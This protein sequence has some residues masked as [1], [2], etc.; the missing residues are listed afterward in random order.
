MHKLTKILESSK[1]LREYED[2]ELYSY[3]GIT[4]GPSKLKGSMLWAFLEP[5]VDIAEAGKLATVETVN[6]FVFLKDVV[7]S[8]RNKDLDLAI[9]NFKKRKELIQKDWEPLLKKNKEVMDRLGGDMNM[10][11]LGAAPQFFLVNDIVKKTYA[12]TKNMKQ[13]LIKAGLPLG[14]LEIKAEEGG[15]GR[16]DFDPELRKALRIL[17]YGKESITESK[18]ISLLEQSEK[19]SDQELRNKIYEVL[20]ES[21]IIDPLMKMSSSFRNDLKKQAPKEIESYNSL[22]SRLEQF[23]N[24]LNDIN[25][26]KDFITKSK[27]VFPNFSESKF[28]QEFESEFKKV[29]ED[30][31]KKYTEKQK[32]K[33]QEIDE[34]IEEEIKQQATTIVLKGQKDKLIIEIDK[35]L[36]E[37]LNKP[38]KELMSLMGTSENM[39]VFQEVDPSFFKVYKELENTIK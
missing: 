5:W 13:A 17:F 29:Y 36:Q 28:K 22:K 19:I 23:K 7:K 35:F 30:V 37:D 9:Q 18:K 31:K 6:L 11:L 33:T 21:G 39:K 26:P 1:K 20:D 2:W 10:V 3:D 15:S 4:S 14:K 24:I 8:L 32:D 25:N 38:I 16:E 27:S 12:A 34:K